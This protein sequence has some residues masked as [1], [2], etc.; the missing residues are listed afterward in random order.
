MYKQNLFT[1]QSD[2]NG[3]YYKAGGACK[4]NSYKVAFILC[5]VSAALTMI[6]IALLGA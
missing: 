2:A 1:Q 5:A 4:P 6:L 3:R